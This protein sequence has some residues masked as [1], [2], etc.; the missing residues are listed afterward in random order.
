VRT[1]IVGYDRNGRPV[2]A[3]EAKAISGASPEWAARYRRNLLAQGWLPRTP[4][5]LIALPDMFYL[6][7]N[8]DGTP[9]PAGFASKPTYAIDVRP[10]IDRYLRAVNLSG[11]QIVSSTWDLLLNQVLTDLTFGDV[12]FEDQTV[13]AELARSGL[14]DALNGGKLVS[15]VELE[16][17]R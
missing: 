4:Y 10:W 13:P 12:T 9:E 7:D 11:D 5:F 16:G 2:L 17:I 1:D 15:E 3:V 14:L 6:W 8:K